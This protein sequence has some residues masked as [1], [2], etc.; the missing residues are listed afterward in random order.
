[1]TELFRKKAMATL[2]TP[3]QLD[4]L[5]CVTTPVAWLALLAAA[6]LTV[7]TVVWAWFGS[8]AVT[9][10]GPGVLLP[11]GGL[12][13]APSLQAGLLT[14]VVVQ[15]DQVVKN[16]SVVARLQPSLDNASNRVEVSVAHGGRVLEILARPGQ[17]VDQGQN[18]AILCE[19]GAAMECVAY[20]AF[21]QGDKLAPGL[22]AR[23]SPSNAEEDIYGSLIGTVVSVSPYP[24]N[25]KEMEAVLAD[26]QLVDLFL[27]GTTFQQAPLEVRIRMNQELS[28][29]SGYA[30]TSGHGPGRALR[31]GTSCQ[32]QVVTDYVRPAE[33]ALPKIRDF[34]DATVGE[35]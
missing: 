15:R 4:T 7:V 23:I 9:V 12:H 30:W 28:D 18:L 35:R 1:M 6:I 20:F 10:T 26:S 32:I 19:P 13:P 3:E 16:N 2:A 11:V 5:L 25:R 22:P 29:P 34:F 21:D 24:A 14:E 33:L 31:S 27:S 17:Y 8:L